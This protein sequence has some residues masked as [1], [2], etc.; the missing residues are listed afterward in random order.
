MGRTFSLLLLV[1]DSSSLGLGLADLTEI[2]TDSTSGEGVGLRAASVLFEGCSEASDEGVEASPCLLEGA[3]ARGR[4][5]WVTEVGAS[6]DVD[7]CLPE[8]I[9][10]LEEL[11]DV[12]PAAT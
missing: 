7:F 11:D 9:Q 6:R 3:G 8:L 4:W 1:R 10:V 12:C 5:V 2:N